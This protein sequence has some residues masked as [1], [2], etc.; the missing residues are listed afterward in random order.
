MKLHRST[1]V[2][3]CQSVAAHLYAV[4]YSDDVRSPCVLRAFHYNLLKNKLFFEMSFTKNNTQKIET[5]LRLTTFFIA[6]ENRKTH[7]NKV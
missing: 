7:I 1:G 2:A 5:R 6:A 3:V 4:G